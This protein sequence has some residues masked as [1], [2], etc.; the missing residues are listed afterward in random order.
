MSLTYF[1]SDNNDITPVTFWSNVSNI[2]HY[3]NKATKHKLTEKTEKKK[4]LVF[5]VWQQEGEKTSFMSELL[6]CSFQV[7]RWVGWSLLHGR[8]KCASSLQWKCPRRWRRSPLLRT[9]AS[10]GHSEGRSGTDTG[11][12]S[13]CSGGLAGYDGAASLQDGQTHNSDWSTQDGDS[14][15]RRS[16]FCL[17][18]KLTVWWNDDT[19]TKY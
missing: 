15:D 10:A 6:H 13:P 17:W 8:R 18:Q 4:S 19:I 7:G 2:M 1:R 14:T 11:R 5:C 16:D 3:L 9:Q 12:T